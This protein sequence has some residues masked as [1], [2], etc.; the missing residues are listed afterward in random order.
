MAGASLTVE[1]GSLAG[2]S[3]TAGGGQ[4]GGANGQ[5]FGAGIFLQGDETI[6]F[7]PVK[8]TT[9]RVFDAIADQTGSGGT[10]A[11]AGAGGLILDGAGTLDLISA[12]TYTGGTT[13][14]KGILELAN[15]GAAGRSRIDFASTSG[16]VE[17]A[18]GAHLANRISGF[19]GSDKIDFAQVSFAAG[20]HSVDNSGTVSI[21]TSAGV[22]VATFKVNGTYTSA[23]FH[24][25]KDTS[26]HVLVTFVAA[27]A[28]IDEA[29]VSS[30]DFLGGHA[31][32]FPMPIV[33]THNGLVGLDS[34]L[35]P[36]PG[37][38]T[39]T[40]SLADRQ[41]VGG[42]RDALGVSFGGENSIGHAPGP[43]G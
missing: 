10:G 27:A 17:Y 13:I 29:G 34:L 42:G 43:G 36:V 14:D 9:E 37:A 31:S 33:E 8:G 16:E 19:R 41:Y 35:P 28:A 11:N 40:G 21:K 12:S 1:G 5:A 38:E 6:T 15:A 4:S 2:A 25:G 39:Y 20:D 23:N 18:A 30:A 7:A 24:V 3:V 26:G 32:Q 22:T